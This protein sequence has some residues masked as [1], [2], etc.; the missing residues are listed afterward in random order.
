MS[1]GFTFSQPAS[2]TAGLQNYR[3][4]RGVKN[5]AP[6]T[7][8]LSVV[9]QR[10]AARR[11]AKLQRG[12]KQQKDQ[13]MSDDTMTKMVGTLK[14]SVASIFDSGAPN[15]DDLISR[16][17]AEFET[18]MGQ[19]QAARLTKRA[20]DGDLL[21]KGL[22]TVGRVANLLSLITDKVRCIEAGV[23][24]KGQTADEDADASS[25]EVMAYLDHMI[26]AGELA[27]SQAVNE[28]VHLAEDD[29][30]GGDDATDIIKSA[31][32]SDIRI[33]TDLPAELVKFA[34]DPHLMT[35]ALVD[36]A[37]NTLLA[38]GANPA[39]LNKLFSAP[40][41]LAKSGAVQPDNSAGPTE[42][43]PADGDDSDQSGEGG[44]DDAASQD[45][46]AAL[47]VV[48]RL[49]AAILIQ[50]DGIS[51]SLGGEDGSA[52]GS[53]PTDPGATA[54]ATPPVSGDN[55]GA[56]PAPDP[57]KKPPVSYGGGGMAKSADPA[58]DALQKQ[59]ADLSDQLRKV[60]ALPQV[61]K[62]ALAEYT[63]NLQKSAES[64]LGEPTLDEAAIV[65]ALEKLSPDEKTVAQIKLARGVDP[66]T[67]LRL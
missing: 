48:G 1:D 38:A 62:G 40:N 5:L 25:E 22:G 52:D 45:P 60:M 23:D 65:D 44:P 18:A 41:A 55:T 46:L 58:V 9:G 54:D 56:G 34:V 13:V 67:A 43:G 37:A 6:A 47:N 26:A 31:D 28:H 7:A 3:I 51:R 19:Y 63:D 20:P 30:E 59:V 24:Y 10:A 17:F 42:G 2:P 49:A 57:K 35:A 64:S 33:K 16:T 66:R 14:S 15:R 21:Y 8:L 39:V 36:D 53:D 29:G 11:R 32:G 4:E 12:G 27:L 61:P 50:I